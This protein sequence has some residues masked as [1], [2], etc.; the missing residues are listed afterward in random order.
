MSLKLY[1]HPF[2]SFC[3]KVLIALYENGTPFEPRLVDFSNDRSAAEFK[4]IW[5]IGKMPVLRDDAANRTIP[6]SSIIIEY[7]SQHYPGSVELLP[8]APEAAL[9]TRLWD[10]FFDLHVEEPM[11]KIVGDRLRPAD[12]KDPFGVETARAML[13]VAYGIIERHM[14]TKTWATGDSFTMADCAAAPALF[15]ADMVDPPGDQNPIVKA[16]L[17]RLMRRLSFARVVEEAR[18]YR[19]SF[20]K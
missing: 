6:E 4:E 8:A 7:L 12:K 19:S 9:Q 11:Q 16:Y 1:S 10:R 18:P 20:P 14:A 3:Q 2:S 5:P 15:Y 13:R 17:A